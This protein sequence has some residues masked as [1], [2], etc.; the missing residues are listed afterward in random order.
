MLGVATILVQPLLYI[1]AINTMV[2][3][4]DKWHTTILKAIVVHTLRSGVVVRVYLTHGWDR[5]Q[6]PIRAVPMWALVR[7][8]AARING[9]TSLNSLN[10][11]NL[12]ISSL[13]R[14]CLKITYIQAE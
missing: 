7:T 3:R 12:S 2:Q 14:I 9:C 8:F 10:I 11:S 6:T 1:L 13:I 5:L 4:V